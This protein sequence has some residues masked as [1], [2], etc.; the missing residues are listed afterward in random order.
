VKSTKSLKIR[1]KRNSRAIVRSAPTSTH[2]LKVAG[3]SPAQFWVVRAKTCAAVFAA[4][5]PAEASGTTQLF[6]PF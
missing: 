4:A 5:L 3:R 2:N 6:A 1:N